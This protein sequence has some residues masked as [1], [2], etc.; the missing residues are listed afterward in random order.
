V[1]RSA[2]LPVIQPIAVYV[3]VAIGA[4]AVVSL[5]ALPT[6]RRGIRPDAL[7]HE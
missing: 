7:H 5:A 4:G 2:V 3:W 1:D 6:L